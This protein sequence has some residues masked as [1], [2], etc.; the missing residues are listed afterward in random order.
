MARI[1]LGGPLGT[2]E[3]EI[4]HMNPNYTVIVKSDGTEL[5]VPTRLVVRVERD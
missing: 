4:G 3:G 5:E 1:I 2:V